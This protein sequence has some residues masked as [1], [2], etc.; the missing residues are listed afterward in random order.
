[1]EISPGIHRISGFVNQYLLVDGDEVILIDTGMKSNVDKILKYLRVNNLDPARLRQI[2]ITHSDADHY[3]AANLISTMT[4]AKLW[5]SKIEADAMRIGSSSRPIVPRGIFAIF[6]PLLKNVLSSPPV[7]VDKLIEDGE[8]LPI[9]G[10][11][12][13]I[14][15]PGHTPGHLSFYLTEKKILFAGDAI[16]ADKGKP[17][18][19]ID[20]TTGN[21]AQAKESFNKLMSLQPRVIGCGH[22]Y[23]DLRN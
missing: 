18:P 20:A 23:F 7:I 8:V 6:F 9:L 19:T 3:G 21:P 15:S 11:L 2:L 17:A 1:L 4:G 5:T 13:V 16:T 12:K 14:A 10:G 22:A